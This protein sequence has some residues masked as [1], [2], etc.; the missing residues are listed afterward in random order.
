MIG[1]AETLALETL[2]GNRELLER[3]ALR[4]I[5]VE[6]IDREELERIIQD[7]SGE[8]EEPATVPDAPASGETPT[9]ES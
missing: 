6:L 8:A 9:E 1:E 7:E 4:L 3:I 5:E 2:R